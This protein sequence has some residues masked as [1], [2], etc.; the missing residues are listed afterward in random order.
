MDT[1][2]EFEDKYRVA[3][4]R[5]IREGLQSGELKTQLG[6]DQRIELG[7]DVYVPEDMR[8][9]IKVMANGHYKPDWMLLADEIDEDFA[10]LQQMADRH[11]RHLRDRLAAATQRANIVNLQTEVNALKERHRKATT[12]YAEAVAEINRKIHQ[13]NATVPT[14]GRMRGTINTDEAM[15]RFADRLPAYLTY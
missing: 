5:R 6:P 9:A 4:E 14:Q 12:Q 10:K 15:R 11:F 3:A 2:D 13:F 8:L 7:N 1:F